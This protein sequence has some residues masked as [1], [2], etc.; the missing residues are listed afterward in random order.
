MQLLRKEVSEN[1]TTEFSFDLMCTKFLVKNLTSGKIYACLGNKYIESSSSLILTLN[2]E[3]LIV[4]EELENP[5][6]SVTVYSEKAGEIE[7][8]ALEYTC[9]SVDLLNNL[10]IIEN[11]IYGK[12]VR[13]AIH[14][15][16]QIINNRIIKIEKVL[17]IKDDM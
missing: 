15:S 9:L 7:V 3:Y 10:K 14:D 6:K 16:I 12:D 4:N 17:N 5:T 2:S 1:S 13:K 8:Q 11:G